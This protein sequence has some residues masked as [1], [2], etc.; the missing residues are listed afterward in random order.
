MFKHFIGKVYLFEEPPRQEFTQLKL[1]F[2]DDLL[3]SL[4]KDKFDDELTREQIIKIIAFNDEMDNILGK[5]VYAKIMKDNSFQTFS[6]SSLKTIAIDMRNNPDEWSGLVYL[7]ST[8]PNEW[9]R[10]LYLVLK[11]LGG[12]TGAA[13]RDMV[14][15][16]K[17]ISNNWNRPIPQIISSLRNNG[18]TIEKFFELERVASFRVASM[19]K[20]I[21]TLQK[22]IFTNPSD[23]S[24]FIAKIS[25]AF[26]PKLVYEL[27][28]YGLPRM[29]SKRIQEAGVINLEDTELSIHDA[30][31]QFNQ[32][33]MQS[34]VKKVGNLHPFESYI[35]EYFYDGIVAN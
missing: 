5:D 8:N 23:I 9:D 21:N 28:E 10:N 26:L 17:A 20:D 16:I 15:Y 14:A 11:Y 22:H 33:G 29:V 30:I 35:L 7:N 32:V 12:T 27:E 4:D 31:S 34:L 18:V 6:P 3:N 13:Y 25:H 1:E 24:P 2:T 19:L